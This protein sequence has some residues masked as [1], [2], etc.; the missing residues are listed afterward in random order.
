MKKI[1]FALVILLCLCSLFGCGPLTPQKVG[2]VYTVENSFPE[3]V[4]NSFGNQLASSINTGNEWHMHVRSPF[5][6]MHSD[7]TVLVE[8][9][10][11]NDDIKKYTEEIYKSLDLGVSLFEKFCVQ[12]NLKIETKS[13]NLYNIY[14]DLKGN[15]P[16]RIS[17]I[18]KESPILFAYDQN[19]R[20]V[21]GLY[22]LIYRRVITSIYDGFEGGHPYIYYLR[23][24]FLPPNTLQRLESDRLRKQQRSMQPAPLP[25]IHR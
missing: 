15:D 3:W 18:V 8:F 7:G 25:T 12:N 11:Y 5:Q 19:G 6:Y 20:V 21:A 9:N 14:S 1:S 13:V 2:E 17:E 10:L 16:K 22:A 4:I 23:F 24:N